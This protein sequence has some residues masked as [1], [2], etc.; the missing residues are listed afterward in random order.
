MRVCNI[1]MHHIYTHT[2]QV[3]PMLNLF[4]DANVSESVGFD[5]N[6][7]MTIG[8]TVTSLIHLDTHVV[9]SRVIF[10][11]S[12]RVFSHGE[13]LLPWTT[14]SFVPR[15]IATGLCHD[16]SLIVRRYV[17]EQSVLA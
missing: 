1:Y 15:R 4:R 16:E 7:Y 11:T 2:P 8:K 17:E 3:L 5:L 10:P 13:T 9:R 14:N 6:T 12:E